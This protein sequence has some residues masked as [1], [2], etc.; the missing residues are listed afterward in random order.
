MLLTSNNLGASNIFYVKPGNKQMDR[1]SFAFLSNNGGISHVHLRG[2][3]S[4]I[5]EKYEEL[6]R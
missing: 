5:I 3:A 6:A 4:M 2:I 1:I